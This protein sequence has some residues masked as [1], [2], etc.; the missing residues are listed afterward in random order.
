M[1]LSPPEADTRRRWPLILTVSS[2]SGPGLTGMLAG[3][4]ALKSIKVIVTVIV[5]AA[6]R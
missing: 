6:G 4:C 3:I 5:A 1:W 2:P